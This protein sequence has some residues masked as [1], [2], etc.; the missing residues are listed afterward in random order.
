MVLCDSSVLGKELLLWFAWSWGKQWLCAS[1]SHCLPPSDD[2][3]LF[4]KGYWWQ[5]IKCKTL[6]LW[7]QSGLMEGNKCLFM[8]LWKVPHIWDFGKIWVL[9]VMPKAMIKFDIQVCHFGSLN[10]VIRLIV[11]D[12][13]KRVQFSLFFHSLLAHDSHIS[14]A[15]L[16][17]TG[18]GYV[19]RRSKLKDEIL[20]F[21][22]RKSVL[23]NLIARHSLSAVLSRVH[24]RMYINKIWGGKILFSLSLGGFLSW[25]PF[26]IARMQSF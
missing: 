16:A 17:R 7:P 21:I 25:N 9:F 15:H 5:P 8:G 12:L 26:E 18:L 6:G 14:S 19:G 20:R 3:H 22:L 23:C 10:W 24:Y 13:E 4:S 11:Q 1:L 2:M